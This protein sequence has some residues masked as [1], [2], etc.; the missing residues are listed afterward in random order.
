MYRYACLLVCVWGIVYGGKG[1]DNALDALAESYLA[2][3]EVPGMAI[4][5]VK[6]DTIY[7][8]VAGVKRIGIPD[9]IDLYSKFQ[10]SSNTKAITAAIAAT[11]V[12]SGKIEWHSRIVDVI[13]SLAGEIRKEYAN[14]TLEAL[15]SNRGM[16]RPFEE[17]TSK[18]WR[19][20][21]KSLASSS[22]PKI[23][24]SK[25]ALNLEPVEMGGES[26]S[27]SNGG[28]IIAGLLLER[29]SGKS[30][31]QLVDAFTDQFGV[32]AFIGFPSQESTAGTHGHKKKSGKYKPVTPDEE[33]EL[34]SFFAPAGNLSVSILELSRLMAQHLQGL[35]GMDN[36]LRSTTYEKLHYGLEDYALGW[37]NGKIGDTEQQFS[38]HGG[39][40]GTYSS[41]IM[42]SADREVAILVLINSDDKK[43][44]ELKNEIRK[45]LW[46]MYGNTQ[47]GK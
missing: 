45:R 13:P 26:H 36:I 44:S 39:S 17:N 24:F 30:W 38:Y 1:Q 10:I 11:L 25:Y 28:F 22:N 9:E 29:C 8:G 19:N 43:T 31:E 14:V 42:I 34:G 32:E 3:Y 21:P 12:E 46:E 40:L 35:M 27:Y 23:A 15:L 33:E 18:E 16:I 20:M 2:K 47:S 7:Y 6:P 37:Y 4:S 41:A 5:V